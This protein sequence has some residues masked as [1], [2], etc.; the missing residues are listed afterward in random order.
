MT[1]PLLRRFYCS[2]LITPFPSPA[3]EW[4]PASSGLRHFLCPSFEDLVCHLPSKLGWKTFL[5][6]Q[7][8]SQFREEFLLAA[9][10]SRSLCEIRRSQLP[11]FGRPFQLLSYNLG[12]PHLT[13]INNFRIRLVIFCSVLASHTEFFHVRPGRVRDGCCPICCSDIENPFH[14]ICHYPCLRSVRV[15]HCWPESLND[16]T[17]FDQ[18]LGVSSEEF[19]ANIDR[20]LSDL[21]S[22]RAALL[23]SKLP[24]VSPVAIVSFAVF[25]SDFVFGTLLLEEAINKEEEEGTQ[26]SKSPGY[27]TMD[28]DNIVR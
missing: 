17:L 18:C 23:A 24:V 8:H 21:R 27:T 10:C 4:S 19:Q 2:V 5:L 13:R 15:R 6:T 1:L 12:D 28:A 9:G 16:L 7:L 22:A 11:R 25:S 14:L 26:K 3:H 20:F